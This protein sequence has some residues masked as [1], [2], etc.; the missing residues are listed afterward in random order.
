M[1]WNFLVCE[2]C[3]AGQLKRLIFIF[4]FLAQVSYGQL[5]TQP[6]SGQDIRIPEPTPIYNHYVQQGYVGTSTGTSAQPWKT[7]QDAAAVAIAGQSIGIRAGDYRETITPANSGTAANPI[8]FEPIA[9]Q[10]VT[11]NG[12]ELVGN[13]GWTVHSGDIYK[14]TITLPVNGY[15]NST[16]NNTT[17]LANQV[18]KDRV[19]MIEARWP[20][21]TNPDEM[22][23]RTKVRPMHSS[24]VTTPSSTTVVDAA[25]PAGMTGAEIWINGWYLTMTA[26]VTSHSGS[27]ITFSPGQS[28]A[29]KR[30]RYYLTKKLSLL[31]IA[32]EWHYES[33][34]LYFWQLGGGSPTGVEY[35]ARNYGFDLTGKD[36]ITIKGIE[37]F[38]C[39]PAQGSTATD[40]ITIDDID[41]TYMNHSVAQRLS[42]V[43]YGNPKQTGIKLLGSNNVIKNSRLSY[44]ASQCIW[45]GEGGKV[46][47]CL[48]HH[49]SYEGNYG[50]GVTL[51]ANT[52]NQKVL[53]STFYTLGR[54][55]VDF[56]DTDHGVHANVEIGYNDMYDFLK[57][58]LDG[59]AV[60]AGR[61]GD[62][63]GWR[64]H[65]NWVHDAGIQNLGGSSDPVWV[66]GINTGLYFDQGTGPEV[67]QT[68]AIVDHNILWNN[69]QTDYFCQPNYTDRIAG[70]TGIYNNVFATASTLPNSHSYKTPSTN[71]VDVQ[72]NNI[73]QQDVIANFSTTLPNI[74]NS[75]GINLPTSGTSNVNSNPN[76]IATGADG[77]FYRITGS[78]ALN[79]GT[80]LLPYTSNAVGA[81]DIG[82]YEYT[83][84][85]G[86][87][88]P[89][90]KE[91]SDPA[92]VGDYRIE[93]ESFDS[94]SAGVTTDGANIGSCDQGE[95]AQYDINFTTPKNKII[96]NYGRQWL[97]PTTGTVEIRLGS[98]S[99]TLMG[100]VVLPNT[101]AWFTFVDIEANI[102]AISGV[103][104]LFIVFPAGSG[105]GNGNFNW[106]TF[107]E[108]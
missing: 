90:Y 104:S 93:A 21:I 106:Y 12:T 55:A 47:N 52:G 61:H 60:Y 108:Q 4:L 42:D 16:S 58:N 103:Q 18:F 87:W 33:G 96:I 70:P 81:P 19:M 25:A 22:W 74:R 44:A 82:G 92:P 20:N 64:T 3:G 100:T 35:K 45:L 95:F 56:G 91:V 30:D 28:D 89:G 102:T 71:P 36:Y 77:L 67:G 9:G 39:T 27:T 59:G 86:D 88:I 34:T 51:W 76:F 62:L 97:T 73:Y 85:A 14:K 5:L 26:S 43:I 78:P 84:P 79:A 83:D 7:I 37:F 31:D 13:T 75:I 1:V 63:R 10:P 72:R 17:I 98:T 29:L 15:N 80:S 40:N 105:D 65:H 48:I 94:K 8:L 6:Y 57:M 23:D 66:T 41:A 38:G 99:G 69:W 107:T 32:R 54:S 49:I 24:G 50:A 101:G 46:D 11:V 68:M 53:N 2:N